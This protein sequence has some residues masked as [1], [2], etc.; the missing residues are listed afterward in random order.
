MHCINV[1]FTLNCNFTFTGFDIQI[2]IYKCT[3][4]ERSYLSQIPYLMVCL[5]PL[6]LLLLLIL[7]QHY[8]PHH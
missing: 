8:P 1:D 3:D 4:Y 7:P 2:Y 5:V 6:L